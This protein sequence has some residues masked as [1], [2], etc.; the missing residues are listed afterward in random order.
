MVRDFGDIKV[1]FLS[2]DDVAWFHWAG[3]NRWGTNTFSRR[4]NSG[5]LSVDHE[6]IKDIVTSASNEVDHLI[7]FMS[8]GIEYTNKSNSHQQEM[9]HAIIDAGA[10]VIYGTHPHWIQGFEVYKNKPVFYSL[11]N[12]VFDQTHT[13]PTRQGI[14]LNA[15]FYKGR[16]INFE[17]IPQKACGYHQTTN[18]L[19]TKIISGE[20]SYEE[21]D[22]FSEREGCVYWQPTPVDENSP[23][24]KQSW[25]RF[26]EW[27]TL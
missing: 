18:N 6:R 10:D 14:V 2:A 20:L 12:F 19:A 4:D 3:E 7:V 16:L 24:Y 1:G 22:N 11:G 21:V 27:T 17:I 26:I 15:N 25:E 23:H 9:A 5:G 8:W 13:D